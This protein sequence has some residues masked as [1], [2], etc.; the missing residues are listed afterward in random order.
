LTQ[1]QPFENLDQFITQDELRQLSDN[2]KRVAGFAAEGMRLDNSEKQ[3][4]R[5]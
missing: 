1:D 2:Y 3:D 5:G 4:G